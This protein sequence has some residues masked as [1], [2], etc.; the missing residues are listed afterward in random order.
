MRE[1]IISVKFR[2]KIIFV[3]SS[4]KN[5]EAQ[6]SQRCSACFVSLNFAKSLKITLKVIRNSTIRQI[7]YEF[8]LAFHS[9]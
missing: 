1:E 3:H 7:A 5:N 4:S 8:L 6:L 9:N 2:P